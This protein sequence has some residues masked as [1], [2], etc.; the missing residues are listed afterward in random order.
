LAEH[1]L[2]IAIIGA[3][4]SG[5][6][7]AS[8]LNRCGHRTVLFEKSAEI[9]G[10]WAVSYPG[11]T[12]QNTG[13]QYALSEFPWPFE[14]DLHPTGAQI[15]RYLN[16]AVEHLELDV[17]L[18]HE[19]VLL[20]RLEKGWAV[21]YR[22]RDGEHS[23]EFDYVIVAVGQYTEWKHAPEF[24]G[25][26]EF[27]GEIIT[28]RDVKDLSI[29]DDKTTVVIGFGKS[30]VDMASAAVASAAQV[31]HVART[32]RWMIPFNILGIHYTRLLFCRAGT[33]IMKSWAHPTKLERFIHQRLT[34]LIDLMWRGA[35]RLFRR[36]C[37][38]HAR[39]LGA[40]ARDR[41]QTVLPEHALVGDLRSAA[42]MAPRPYYGQVARGEILPRHAELAGYSKTGVVLGDG[43][44]IDCDQVL[45]C[46]GSETPRFPFFP[47]SYRRLLEGEPD[48]VQLYRH[49]LH[50][51]IPDL[52]FAGYNH[53][54]MHIPTA[55]VG[56]VWL[57][58]LLRGDIALPSTEDMLASIERVRAWKRENI[59]FEPSRS[60]AI[61][62][63]F[64]Q[65]NDIILSELGLSPYRKM[66]NVFAEVFSQ[67]GAR[68]YVGLVEEYEAK[69][70]RLALP[71]SVLPL[72]T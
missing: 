23:E 48:G 29:F 49:I 47:E 34:W 18:N 8:I 19:V 64:Q 24:P 15:Q 62:M 39:G 41:L 26:Q 36:L 65:Y 2:R 22:N 12:L 25:Q 72:D 30:A 51:Q 45:L 69:R 61:N 9:G 31:H 42:A 59:N 63:R 27:Q 68:D 60:C 10:V 11:V 57:S 6:A 3:G 67:Y 37:L 66:P 50:P 43:S 54:F 55:E 40:A 13:L 17:R 21:H 38:N 14:P 52:A 16:A 7:T 1:E 5:I 53:G 44:S 4:I 20:E 71:R 32:P 33:M 46:V 70:K 58:A 56:T 28:E 35:S